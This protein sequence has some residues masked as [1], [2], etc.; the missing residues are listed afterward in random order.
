[1]SSDEP[2]PSGKLPPEL[3]ASLL[4]AAPALP[5][6]VRI[7]PAPGEDACAIDVPAGTLVATTDP[8]TLTGSDVARYA[9]AINANDVAAMGVRPRW[10]LAAVLLPVGTTRGEVEDLFAALREATEAAGA[11]L[12]GG[13]TEITA[14]VAQPL[15]VG[16]MLG[17]AEDGRVLSSGGLEPDDVVFQVG[18]API[19]AAA[20]LADRFGASLAGLS[21][22]LVSA[23]RDAVTDPGISVVEAG[24]LAASLG[25][26]A[27]HDPTEGGLAS[28]L[29]EL[30][31]ASG[32]GLDLHRD[33]VL[34][35]EPGV[36]VCRALGADPWGALASG[37]LLVGFAPD[38][39]EA[40]L[41]GF[42]D[43]GL[44]AAPIARAVAGRG[45][46]LPRFSR[47]EVAR[48]HEEEG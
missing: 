3:L 26:K 13:H 25:A 5:P 32:V 1:M 45:T 47:D 42:A 44:P 6:E 9:V 40:A 4:G 46:G 30:A 29:G 10:M 38:R 28:G 16:Q 18:R 35:F 34:W 24:L 20:V 41:A 23:A 31:A 19:E 8:I 22:A 21:D 43:A 11:A 48:L 33:A 36:A 39:A 12:V 15:V 7:G 2:L 14:A 17:L 27:A 37:C